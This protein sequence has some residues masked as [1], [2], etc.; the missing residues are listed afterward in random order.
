MVETHGLVT[1][2]GAL[3]GTAGR[4]GARTSAVAL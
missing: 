3:A 4:P 2:G 1:D